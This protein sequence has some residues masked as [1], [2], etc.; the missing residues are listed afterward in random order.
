LAWSVDWLEDPAGEP[1]VDSLERLE[2][3][4]KEADAVLDE[5]RLA[6]GLSF[7]LAG[8]VERMLDTTE[9]LKRGGPFRQDEVAHATSQKI[10]LD[11]AVK[12]GMSEQ[13]ILQ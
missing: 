10:T 2:N 6:P 5:L 11:G 1:A 4:L 8:G 13:S 3:L 9:L 12:S 7:I